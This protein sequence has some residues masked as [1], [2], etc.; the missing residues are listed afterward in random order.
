MIPQEFRSWERMDGAQR[1]FGLS[2][3]DI[4]LFSAG[5]LFHRLKRAAGS[6]RAQTAAPAGITNVLSTPGEKLCV[7]VMPTVRKPETAARTI[8]MC[9]KYLVS[10]LFSSH[11]IT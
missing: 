6:G 4:L 5:T 1:V 3:V 10:S 11:T 8:S 7:T 9:A 2:F